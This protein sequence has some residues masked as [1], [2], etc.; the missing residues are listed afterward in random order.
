M[1][2]TFNPS[3]WNTNTSLVYTFKIKLV[4]RR[5]Q[6]RLKVI[7]NWG[8]DKVVNQRKIWQNESNIGC[9]QLSWEQH[10]KDKLFKSR[11]GRESVQ[12][13]G[14]EFGE[15][16]G[17][18]WVQRSR[19]EFCFILFCFV[20]FCLSWVQISRGSWSQR[21]RRSQKIRINCQSEFEAKQIN[22]VKSR[23][24]PYWISQLG[25]EFEPGQLSWTCQLEFCNN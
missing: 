12:L 25:E 10:R 2:H 15:L 1:T 20:S 13:S 11:T 5:K 9:V 14:V 21:I 19:V 17:S 18:Q 7:S 24:K 16:V 6:P 22:S 8:A 3:G 4:F 23:D